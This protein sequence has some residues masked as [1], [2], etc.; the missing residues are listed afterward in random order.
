MINCST[1][2]CFSPLLI[3]VEFLILSGI[4]IRGLVNGRAPPTLFSTLRVV[5]LLALL[6]A[7]ASRCACSFCAP[8]ASE[9]LLRQ[10]RPAGRRRWGACGEPGS[11]D[12]A[13]QLYSV[14]TAGSWCIRLF[15]PNYVVDSFLCSDFNINLQ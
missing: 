4:F 15:E 2:V 3:S 9:D 5:V 14:Y 1:V 10:A 7:H 6:C 8:S 11:G 13:V 12:Q